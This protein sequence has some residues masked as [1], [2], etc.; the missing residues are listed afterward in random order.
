M[1]GYG[2]S[3]KVMESQGRSLKVIEGHERSWKVLEGHVGYGRWHKVVEGHGKS[4]KVMEGYPHQVHQV[5]DTTLPRKRGALLGQHTRGPSEVAGSQPTGDVLLHHLVLRV[6]L[7][8][9]PR[10]LAVSHVV[11]QLGEI[12][13]DNVGLQGPGGGFM[14][15]MHYLGNLAI[16]WAF[17]RALKSW[18]YERAPKSWAYDRA[19]KSWAYDRT[20]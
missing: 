15:D 1:E 11:Q 19:P 7:G 5:V 13:R 12:Q 8:H 10:H 20:P 16:S 9:H 4:R 2:R 17:D 6:L 14:L 3:W 18:A